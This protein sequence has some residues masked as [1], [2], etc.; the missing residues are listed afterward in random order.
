[1]E[2]IENTVA[3][4]EQLM[5]SPA[6]DAQ[7]AEVI[8]AAD[9]AAELMSGKSAEETAVNTGDGDQSAQEGEPAKRGQ[10]QAKNERGNQMRAALKQQRKTI[11]EDELGESEETVRELIRAHRAAKLT[12]DNPEV[13]PTAARMIVEAQEKTVQPKEDKAMTELTQAVQSLIDDGWTAEELRA[14]AADEK[15]REDMT[16]GKTVRQAARAYEKRQNTAPSANTKRSSVPTFRTAATS[17]VKRGDLIS[18]MSDED[19]ARFSDRAY[20]ALMEG[21]KVTFDE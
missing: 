14:F 4:G 8:S 15:A 3:M 17:G 18:D 10:Q 9:L 2:N 19:F 1:M 20:K 21:K 7:A 16:N 5:E 6:D 11:F 12:K 13:S